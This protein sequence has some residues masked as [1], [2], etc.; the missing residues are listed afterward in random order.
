MLASKKVID[1]ISGMF[2]TKNGHLF[3]KGTSDLP[4]ILFISGLGGLGSF[5]KSTLQLVAPRHTCLAIDH[6]GMGSMPCSGP[7]SI[8]GILQAA[9]DAMNQHG[10]EKCFVVGHSTGGLVAQAMA[11][12]HSNR[13]SGLILSSTW[14]KTNQRFVDLFRLRQQV[15]REIGYEAYLTLGN[16]LA[17]P[18]EWYEG[19]I[20][21][22]TQKN[23][24]NSSSSDLE[25]IHAR[26][27]MLLGYSRVD[28]LHRI[29]C[30]TLVVGA[31][32]DGIVPFIHALELQKLI[33]R[34]EL[35]ELSGGHFT[36]VTRTQEYARILNEFISS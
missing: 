34:A 32:D 22:S 29:S 4:A 21:D 10:I 8:D 27:E 16:L 33:P 11:L 31:Q 35:I 24:S 30:R 19:H 1:Y 6:P 25:T 26:I 5:W 18:V 15:L 13:V 7:Q 2:S 12:D 14:A 36:P 23:K 17:Y 9:L 20:G 28:Q 3:I